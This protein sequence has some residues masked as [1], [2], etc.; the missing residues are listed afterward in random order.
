MSYPTPHKVGHRRYYE[1]E[2]N[3]RGNPRKAWED[4]VEVRVIGFYWPSSTEPPESGRDEVTADV[5]VLAPP[6]FQPGAHDRLVIE[7]DEYEVIGRP[8]DYNHG[9]FGFRPGNAIN[10]RRVEG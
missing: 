2:T 10:A 9:P 1:G 6:A 5:I 8:D 4:P 7:G 3:T